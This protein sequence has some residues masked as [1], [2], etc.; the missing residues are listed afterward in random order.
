MA[1]SVIQNVW[2]ETNKPFGVGYYSA[3][4]GSTINVTIATPGTT[5]DGVTLVPGDYIFLK[6]QTN[7]AENGIYVFNGSA[8]PMTRPLSAQVILPGTFVCVA[9]GTVNADKVWNL[10]TNDPIVMNATSLNYGAVDFDYT[11]YGNPSG[12]LPA[13]AANPN[14]QVGSGWPAFKIALNAQ[15][16]K[17]RKLPLASGAMIT[18]TGTYPGGGAFQGG[19]LLP[20]GRVFCVPH[21]STTGRIALTGY[22]DKLDPI[23]TTSPFFNKF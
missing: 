20:D 22:G 3:R 8:A 9:E 7:L 14:P 4:V 11:N 19:V 10:I 15:V 6:N 13:T 18:P 21:G 17:Y 2:V 1:A 5:V 16:D 23:I 12:W